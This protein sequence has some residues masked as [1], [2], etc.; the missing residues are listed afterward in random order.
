MSSPLRTKQIRRAI[1]ETLQMAGGYA[2]ESEVL[3]RHV[4]DL[5]R[6]PLQPNEWNT[7]INWLGQ[8]EHV[9][10]VT[11]DMDPTLIQWTIT[12]RGKTLLQATQV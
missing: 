4:D 3:Q 9:R 7:Q 11:E 12:T 6:P 5:L 1:L 10:R 2:L 8:N